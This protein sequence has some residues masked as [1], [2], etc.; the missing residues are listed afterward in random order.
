MIDKCST[1]LSL[2]S[3]VLRDHYLQPSGF[4]V[5]TDPWFDRDWKGFRVIFRIRQ[6]ADIA[7][8]TSHPITEAAGGGQLAT[9]E[10]H[11]LGPADLVDRQP[12][13]SMMAE[14]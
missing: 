5:A 8:E 13:T 9:F 14:R 11:R 7:A 1:G 3:S 4:E 10:G 12:H 2:F 6:C